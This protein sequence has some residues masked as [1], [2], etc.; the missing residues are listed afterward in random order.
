MCCLPFIHFFGIVPV[1][2]FCTFLIEWFVFLLLDL[3]NYLYNLDND[4]L[5]AM[6]FANIFSF[7]EASLFIFIVVSFTE[8]KFLF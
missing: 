3:K 5:L 7:S 2:T 6:H 4:L 1:Q 8:Q